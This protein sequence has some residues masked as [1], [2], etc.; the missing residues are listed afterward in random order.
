MQT[1]KLFAASRFTGRLNEIERLYQEW[2][3]TDEFTN[4]EIASIEARVI[5]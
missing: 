5:Q 2:L 3:L 1:T 4:R